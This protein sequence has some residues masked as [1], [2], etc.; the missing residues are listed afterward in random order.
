M[1]HLTGNES[2]FFEQESWASADAKYKADVLVKSA[3]WHLDWYS[4]NKNYLS[5]FFGGE[6]ER[7][8]KI[9]WYKKVVHRC[10]TIREKVYKYW[11]KF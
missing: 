9:E 4:D 8:K 10:E 2:E 11:D 3:R 7:Q 5:N 1:N 6:I